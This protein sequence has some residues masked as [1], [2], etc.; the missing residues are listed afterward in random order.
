MTD[1]GA[2]CTFD[3]H[4][5]GSIGKLQELKHI[6]QRADVVDRTRLRIV[7]GS[8]H[9]GCEKDLLLRTHHFFQRLDRFLAPY[10]KRHDHVREH[11]DVAQREDRENAVAGRPGYFGHCPTFHFAA[12]HGQPRL[13]INGREPIRLPARSDNGKF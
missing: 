2:R 7:V 4:L 8:V 9:L 13:H 5:Y 11:D 1:L 6:R 3:E 12:A 10:E